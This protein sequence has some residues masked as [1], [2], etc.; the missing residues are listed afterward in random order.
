M[1][2]QR[3]REIAETMRDNISGHADCEP[4]DCGYRG[5][6]DAL[7]VLIKTALRVERA[8]ALDKQ[9]PISEMDDDELRELLGTFGDVTARRVGNKNI[10]SI[11][12]K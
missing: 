10:V 11:E 6:Y 1:E 8:I 12:S 4:F 7:E 5:E 9:K 2:L 3:A